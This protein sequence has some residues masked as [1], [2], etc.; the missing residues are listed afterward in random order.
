MFLVDLNQAKW[1]KGKHFHFRSFG[2]VLTAIL[3]FRLHLREW[4]QALPATEHLSL[5]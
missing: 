3:A 2:D 5:H 4:A 1:R